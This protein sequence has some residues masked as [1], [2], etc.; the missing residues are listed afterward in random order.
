MQGLDVRFEP[1]HTTLAR[2]RD[3]PLVIQSMD[4]WVS[5][6]ISS[7]DFSAAWAAYPA[8]KDACLIYAVAVAWRDSKDLAQKVRDRYVH[9]GFVNLQALT[10]EKAY[11]HPR[12]DDGTSSDPA[13]QTK[14]LEMLFGKRPTK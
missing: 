11:R 8:Y 3:Q 5:W 12:P 14:I 4:G 1:F 7:T 2:W 9:E 10:E 6:G 13:A